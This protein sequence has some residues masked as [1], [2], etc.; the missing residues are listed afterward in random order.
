MKRKIF[1]AVAL[2]GSSLLQAGEK[3]RPAVHT[4]EY[5]SPVY[6]IDR[7]YRSEEGP[8]TTEPVSLEDVS[9][10]ELVWITGIRTSLVAA[11]GKTPMPPEFMCHV[12][13]NLDLERHRAAFDWK[14]RGI[15]RVLSLA[16]GQLSADLPKG[17]GVPV[18]SDERLPLHTKVLNHNRDGRFQVRHRVTIDFVRDRDLTEPMQPLFATRGFV[19]VPV[20]QTGSPDPHAGHA[21]HA[22][23][24][25]GGSPGHAA[26]TALMPVNY[27]D[28]AGR[29]FVGHWVVPPGREVRRK[30]VTDILQI[31]YD[32]TLHYVAVHV[33]PF[34]ESLEL[35]DVTDGRTVFRSRSQAPEK[36]IGLAH[37]DSFSSVAGVPVYK[38][39]QYELVSVYNNTTPVNQDSMAVM[40]LLLR[41]K[42]F[43]KPN[44]PAGARI[45][46]R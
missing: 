19:A 2:S 44:L 40:F 8:K 15:V 6:T 42:Q 32:T 20:G 33:H 16:Q 22:E 28:A 35:R 9:P 25:D 41:D 24:A 23:D 21:G 10:P 34:N 4:R 39:H 7:R 27:R 29:E 46:S 12:S 11:D 36:G 26:P 5:L 18:L 13:L 3:T 43:H 30:N 45:G 17:F 38:S 1:L 31:P 37:V 14:N